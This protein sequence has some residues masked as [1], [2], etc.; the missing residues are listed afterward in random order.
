M[1]SAQLTLVSIKLACEFLN[2]GG[3]FVTKVFRSKDYQV[4]LWVFNQLFKK[5][6]ATKPQAS[7]NESAE[8][9]V[10]CQGYLA[11]DKIGETDLVLE[12]GY[13]VEE[14]LPSDFTYRHANK[15][16]ATFY[17]WLVL[18]C[19]IHKSL[20]TFKQFTYVDIKI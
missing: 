9:F 14:F 5:V 8:I 15:I 12:I 18:V 20:W 3:W 6:H 1:I 10:V 13:T 7:R 2:K 19:N 11:P 4:L 16:M 17:K